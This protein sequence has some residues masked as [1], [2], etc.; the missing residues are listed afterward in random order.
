MSSEKNYKASVIEEK[1]Y[2]VEHV[3]AEKIEKGKVSF[4]NGD[5]S[6]IAI[7]STKTKFNILFG[8]LIFC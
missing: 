6:P 2:S 4:W 1:E 3:V 8:D 5:D 7:M